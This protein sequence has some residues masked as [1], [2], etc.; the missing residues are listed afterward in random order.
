MHEH[1][2]REHNE[3]HSHEMKAGYIGCQHAGGPLLAW[4]ASLPPRTYD[5]WSPVLSCRRYTIALFRCASL[6]SLGLATQLKISLLRVVQMH[7]HVQ[8][9]RSYKRTLSHVRNV[10]TEAAVV[11]CD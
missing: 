2:S 4:H 7:R 3:L 5:S 6:A 11:G 1:W 10:F 9:K 8:V